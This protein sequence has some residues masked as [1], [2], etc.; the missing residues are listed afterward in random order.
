LDYTVANGLGDTEA[1]PT[2]ARMGDYLEAVDLE[3]EDHGAAWV[4]DG[5]DNSL[6]YN[7]DGVLVFLRGWTPAR[8]LTGISRERALLCWLQLIEGHLEELEKLLW[9]PGLRPPM[10]IEEFERQ[11]RLKEDEQLRTDWHFFQSLGPESE[12]ERC[13]RRGCAH[14]RIGAGA[15]CRA[16]H[17][18]S[19]KGRACPFDE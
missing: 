3:D 19:V 2:L 16:H 7:S 6:Q 18:E 9:Q 13:R 4:T 10:P 11:Q 14:G 12:S 5:D 8:H 1:H 15:L 17:F